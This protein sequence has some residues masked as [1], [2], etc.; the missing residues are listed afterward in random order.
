MVAASTIQHEH[1]LTLSL[2]LILCAN[3]GGG[4]GSELGLV[5]AEDPQDLRRLRRRCHP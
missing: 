2:S 4:A 1:G 3:I 5:G